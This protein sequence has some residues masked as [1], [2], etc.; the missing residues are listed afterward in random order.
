MFTI[1][2]KIA[3]IFVLSKLLHFQ[4]N[5]NQHLNIWFPPHYY[6]S[7]PSYTLHGASTYTYVYSSVHVIH[8]SPFTKYSSQDRFFWIGKTLEKEITVA[9]FLLYIKQYLCNHT[10]YEWILF[11]STSHRHLEFILWQILN[12]NTKLNLWNTLFL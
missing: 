9:R 8:F 6:C 11:N 1:L 7:L 10:K 2:V 4:L 5:Y 3:P 12:I